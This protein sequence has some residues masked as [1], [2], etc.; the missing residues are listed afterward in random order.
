MTSDTGDGGFFSQ[1]A[2]YTG[3]FL[4]VLDWTTGRSYGIIRGLTTE[5]ESCFILL[6]GYAAQ[7][8]APRSAFAMDLARVPLSSAI[9]LSCIDILMMYFS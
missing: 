6:F 2:N 4:I 8:A 3:Y 5:V 1:G 7:A 9:S